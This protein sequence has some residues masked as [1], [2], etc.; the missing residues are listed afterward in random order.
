LYNKNQEETERLNGAMSE[1]SRVVRS[2]LGYPE[3]TEVI[4]DNIG[5]S[6]DAVERDDQRFSVEAE[7]G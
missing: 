7:A 5:Y 4:D 3:A 6:L 2:Q 1:F